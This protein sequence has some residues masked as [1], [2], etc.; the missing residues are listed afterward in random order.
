[1][2]SIM[3]GRTIDEQKIRRCSNVIEQDVEIEWEIIRGAWR[4]VDNYPLK[5]ISKEYIRTMILQQDGQV[6]VEVGGGSVIIWKWA[7]G[8]VKYILLDKDNNII[9]KTQERRFLKYMPFL[10]VKD[11]HVSVDTSGALFIDT[12]ENVLVTSSNDNY[13]HYLNDSVAPLLGFEKRLSDLDIKQLHAGEL[14]DWQ[15]DFRKLANVECPITYSRVQNNFVIMKPKRLFIITYTDRLMIQSKFRE[16]IHIKTRLERGKAVYMTR[17]LVNN[18]VE[19]E[20]EVRDEMVKVGGL[21]IEMDSLTIAEKREILSSCEVLIG[22][23][24]GTMNALMFMNEKA[25]FIGLADRASVENENYLDG[26]WPHYN[27]IS[28]QLRYIVGS[29]STSETSI[30]TSYYDP[31]LL[32]Q[33]LEKNL[34]AN[35]GR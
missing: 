13:T 15:R 33:A 21:C 26:G 19:N 6:L 17:G 24:S 20:D 14:K 5:G 11:N 28:R 12:D 2:K 7:S 31:K 35:F 18:R 9:T 22:E 29:P 30:S 16:T 27:L 23:G 1:M 10:R 4:G 3:T 34:S 25:K 8:E 32:R